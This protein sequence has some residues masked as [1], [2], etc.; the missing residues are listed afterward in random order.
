MQVLYSVVWLGTW[1]VQYIAVH[2]QYG[3]T[4]I[5]SLTHSTHSDSDLNADT[6]IE[7]EIEIKV[8]GLIVL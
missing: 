4:S 8:V 1:E 3:F 5:P 7:V 2:T 6:Y